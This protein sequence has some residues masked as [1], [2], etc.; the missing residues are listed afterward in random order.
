MANLERKM[1]EE[2][3]SLDEG[4]LLTKD[5]A[6]L[7]DY[8]EQKYK[9]NVPRLKE[10][11]IKVDYGEVNVHIR[12]LFSSSGSHVLVD[13]TAI[14]FFI[15]F[16][17]EAILLL[18]R[19]RYHSGD[20]PSGKVLDNELA[21]IY[22]ARVLDKRMV[23]EA[24]DRDLR[25]VRRHL[26]QL[27]ASADQHSSSLRSH[28]LS[29]IEQRR[30]R[31]HSDRDLAQSLGYPLR[32]R[33]DPSQT[34]QLTAIRRK[35]RSSPVSGPHPDT[36]PLDMQDY[37]HILSV[38]SNMVLV[39]ERSPRAFRSMEEEDLR[40]HFLVQLNGQY[41]GQATGETFNAE[42]KVDILVR[43]DGKNIFIAECKFWDG[44]DSLTKA[45]NQV[46]G[47]ATWRDTKLALLIFNRDREF[48]YVL[49]KI[50]EVM[51]QHPNVKG[52][53]D[54]SWF[55]HISTSYEDSC[56]LSA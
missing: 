17:G 23:D 26:E 3:K 18:C 36:L 34:H 20:L 9:M 21:L 31:L 48:S 42:G 51:T 25:A 7:C 16:E 43:V 35:V 32:R 46:L 13:G 11:D 22:S 52:Q 19:P 29:I 50:P 12:D 4:V 28:A 1:V 38:V 2:A 8:F 40:T 39:M 49:S 10:S 44:P 54:Y 27:Q 15:P 56:T 30:A 37:E 24:F 6:E 5:I 47:Y 53:N 55:A 14:T 41:E 33:A 45:L